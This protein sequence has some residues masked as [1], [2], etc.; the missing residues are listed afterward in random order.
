MI[1]GNQ[2][3]KQNAPGVPGASEEGDFLGST[4]T[5]ADFGRNPTT[6]R[7]DD[8]VVGIPGE[9][10]NGDSESEGR[11][12][13]FYGADHGLSATNIQ[14]LSQRS[15]GALPERE[16]FGFGLTLSASSSTDE[17]N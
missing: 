5:D 15:L 6:T 1:V 14:P 16:D 8:L 12:L 11:V 4:M 17:H 3:W 10:L 13:V 9:D 2:L 7:Y